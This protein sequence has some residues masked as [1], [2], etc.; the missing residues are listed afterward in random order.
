[1]SR[2]SHFCNLHRPWLCPNRKQPSLQPS[3]MLM[4]CWF[5]RPFF[6]IHVPDLP[7]F[8]HAPHPSPVMV[9]V[10]VYTHAAAHTCLKSI[11]ARTLLLAPRVS[12]QTH[13]TA[14][15]KK[16][17]MTFT[18]EKVSLLCLSLIFSIRHAFLN[19]AIDLRIMS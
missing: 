14:P 9:S 7:A 2:W 3:L 16:K 19:L 8:R 18:A 17:N 10:R 13:G 5:H 4:Y 11:P 6:C 12:T 15:F 1:M